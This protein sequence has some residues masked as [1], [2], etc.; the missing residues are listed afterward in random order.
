MTCT[1]WRSDGN[2]TILFISPYWQSMWIH[3]KNGWYSRTKKL[4]VYLF[5]WWM[6]SCFFSSISSANAFPLPFIIS[7]LECLLLNTNHHNTLISILITSQP[8]C[9]SCNNFL[10]IVNL[11]DHIS[12]HIA[13]LNSTFKPPIIKLLLLSFEINLWHQL[14]SQLNAKLIYT[15]IN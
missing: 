6:Q 13:P 11:I 4:C 15:K 12:T 7:G 9:T 10:I 3:S 5:Q 14:I 1:L 2:T 8:S